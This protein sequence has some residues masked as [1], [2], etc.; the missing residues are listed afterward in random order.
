M[1]RKL[2]IALSFVCQFSCALCQVADD[3]AAD[4]WDISPA[5]NFYFIPDDFFVLPII[6]FDRHRLH[7]EA[8]YNY[9]DRETFS[10]WAGYNFEGGTKLSYAITPMIGGVVGN[11]NGVA[12]GLRFELAFRRFTLSSESEYFFDL[13]KNENN[14]YYNWSDLSYSIKD[15]LWVGAS[16]QRTKAFQSELDIQYGL[17]V[18]AGYKRWELNTYL[19]NVGSTDTFLMVAV[20]ANF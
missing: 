13:N 10:F 1:T 6:T 17:L 3:E 4:N 14:F 12:P 7:L 11:S 16:G 19:Y 8:R 5:I 9:E 18:G 2:F 15:W 20:S